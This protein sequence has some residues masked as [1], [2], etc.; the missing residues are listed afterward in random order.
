MRRRTFLTLFTLTAA[1]AWPII[2][3]AQQA[4]PP[5]RLG[6]LFG[7]QNDANFRSKF[8]ALRDALQRLGWEEGRNIT[9]DIRWGGNHAEHVLQEAQA[10]VQSKPDVIV[11]GPTNALLPLKKQTDIIPIVFVQVSDPL[12]RGVVTNLARPTGNLTG[13]SNLEFSL[14]G[15]YL[16]ILKEIAPNTSHVAVMIH[17]S[18]AV[19]SSWFRM[20][21]K[22]APSFAI[23]SVNGPVRNNTEIERLMESLSREPNSAL[24]VPGDTYV[25]RPDIRKLIIGLAEKQRL[26][27]LYTQAVFVQE[28]GLICY[29]VDQIEQYRGAASYVD[30]ILKGEKPADLPVQQPAKFNFLINLKTAKKLGLT[31]PMTLQASADEVIE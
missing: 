8:V 20:F 2:V 5:R 4:E 29:G 19:S 14:I 24:I 13:F 23:S 1:A 28:G 18:N 25:E 12:G 15:K 9:Y 27:V 22:V 3:R 17:T 30:R 6:I 7:G 11:A 16:Q 21:D 10:I 31:V 26:P